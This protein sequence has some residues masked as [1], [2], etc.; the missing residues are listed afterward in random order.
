[1][2]YRINHVYAVLPGYL[3][4]LVEIMGGSKA[5]GCPDI[6]ATGFPAG[7]NYCCECMG[8]LNYL[9]LEMVGIPIDHIDTCP[10]RVGCCFQYYP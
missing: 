7:I 9:T 8:I 3:P 10:G 4:C 2:P 6:A 1:M 5:K